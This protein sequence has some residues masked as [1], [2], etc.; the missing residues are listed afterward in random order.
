V[1][2]E[3]VDQALGERLERIVAARHRRRL[4]S[5]GQLEALKAPAG[6]W[7]AGEPPPRPGNRI[8][9][10]IDGSEALPAIVHEIE[11]ARSRVWLAG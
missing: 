10:L 11:C 3:A 4:R 6:G 5:A 2:V 1:G 9:L 7:A 8:K